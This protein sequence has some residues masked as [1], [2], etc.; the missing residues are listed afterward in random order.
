VARVLALA[1]HWRGLIRS[2]ALRDQAELAR[3]MGIS[4][5]RVTQVMDLL[6]LAP[7]IQEEI[8]F[9]ESSG[10]GQ[11]LLHRDMLPVAATPLRADQ[12][13]TWR[14]SR[15]GLHSLIPGPRDCSDDQAKP[16]VSMRLNAKRSPVSFLP[17]TSQTHARKG[18]AEALQ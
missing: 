14:S 17:R 9:L 15:M 10:R 18:D 7:D 11:E 1:D 4:R 2:G 5:S 8:L 13:R 3:L 12:R 16:P 6:R